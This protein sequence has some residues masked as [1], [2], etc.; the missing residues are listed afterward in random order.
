M[1]RACVYLCLPLPL[2][3]TVSAAAVHRG[4]SVHTPSARGERPGK[5]YCLGRAASTTI[6]QNY[7]LR[8]GR[9]TPLPFTY[10]RTPKV[11]IWYTPFRSTEQKRKLKSTLELSLLFR[12]SKRGVPDKDLRGTKVGKWKWGRSAAPERIVL[13]DGGGRRA[14]KAILLTRSLAARARGMYRGPSVYRCGGHRGPKRQR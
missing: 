3:P 9:A 5:Q 8:R 4:P 1:Q 7:S 11:F 2:W 6:Y 10:L 12:G 14:S 13:V